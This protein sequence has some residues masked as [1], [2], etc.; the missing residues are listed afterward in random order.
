MPQKHKVIDLARF[1]PSTSTGRGTSPPPINL[2]TPTVTRAR[3]RRR[4][5]NTGI[6]DVQERPDFKVY[7]PCCKCAEAHRPSMRH[8]SIVDEHI[9]LYNISNKYQVIFILRNLLI[10]GYFY[11]LFV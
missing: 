9:E 5:N 4:G 2:P 10:W 1:T 6:D 3:K 11:L 8:L 7:C